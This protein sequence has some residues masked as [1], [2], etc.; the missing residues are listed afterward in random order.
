MIGNGTDTQSGEVGAFD[1]PGTVRTI[2]RFFQHS[3]LFNRSRELVN[4]YA[5]RRGMRKIRDLQFDFDERAFEL[6]VALR[7]E[8][9]GIIAD[10]YRQQS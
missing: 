1:G 4:G 10:V 3:H 8:G 7:A 5:M 9:L 6:V 2:T